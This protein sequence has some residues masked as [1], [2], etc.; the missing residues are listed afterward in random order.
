MSAYVKKVNFK[1]H[2]SY[3]NPNRGM[4]HITEICGLFLYMNI[5]I[6]TVV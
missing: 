3:A 1:L 4:Y 6:Y 5:V 2:E